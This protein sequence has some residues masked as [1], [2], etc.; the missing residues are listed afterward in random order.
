MSKVL[1]P[2]SFVCCPLSVPHR[3]SDNGQ[4]TADKGRGGGPSTLAFALALPALAL[5]APARFAPVE[6]PVGAIEFDAPVF[7]NRV[8][9]FS[10]EAAARLKGKSYFQFSNQDAIALTAETGGEVLVMTAEEKSKGLSKAPQLRQQGFVRIDGGFQPFGANPA[11]RAE[12]WQKTMAAGEKL[13]LPKCWSVVCGF[14]GSNQKNRLKPLEPLT[15]KDLKIVSY[16]KGR[17]AERTPRDI[18]VNKPDYVVFV[19]RH[20]GRGRDAKLTPAELAETGDTYNDHFQ[21]IDDPK[22]G[23]LFAFWTQATW[24][25]CTDQ[26]IAFS[27]S[28]DKGLTWTDP[29]VLAGSACRATPKLRASWQQ[30]MLAKSGRLYCLWNQQTTSRPPHCGLLFGVYSDDCGDT[31][32]GLEQVPFRE[33]MD[34][35]DADPFV[36]PY[37]CNWQRPLRLGADGRFFV[38]CS[39]HGKAPYD[40]KWSCKIEFWQF[41]NIDENPPVGK[42]RLSHFAKNRDMLSPSKVEPIP[43]VTYFVPREDPAI[44]EA[45][46]VK[47]PDGRL[48]AMMRSSIGCPVWSQS[49]DGGRTWSGAKALLDANGKPFPHPRSPCPLYDWKGP[50]AASGTYFALVHMKFDRNATT[51]YQDRGP[52]YLIAGTFDPAGEQPVRFAAPKLFAPRE[53]GNS[54]YASYTVLDGQG[55]LWFNDKKYYLLGR[56]VGAEWFGKQGCKQT[57]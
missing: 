7:N 15:E 48:F 10:P 11:D 14:D 38:G 52:L 45:A 50:E 34:Q 23:L 53:H 51:A 20:M 46:I 55:V 12:I 13:E 33:R 41:E 57:L 54:F 44:E 35:D 16:L 1:L 31:W 49:R 25:G 29:V 17:P 4:P 9:T 18:L 22:R 28:A 42:I 39:R 32:Q 2:L 37:W 8:F 40:E 47:L 19:P 56:K 24:E 26:H 43:G 5:A 21:V 27:K 30:P 3:S 6:A 36:P